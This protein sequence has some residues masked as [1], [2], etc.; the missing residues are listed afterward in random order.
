MEQEIQRV[1]GAILILLELAAEEEELLAE[2]P[3]N[4]IKSQ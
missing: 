1:N 3:D 2:A 4:S